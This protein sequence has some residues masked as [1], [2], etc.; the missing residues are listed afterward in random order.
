MPNALLALPLP[1]RRQL[2]CNERLTTDLTLVNPLEVRVSPSFT[3]DEFHRAVLA[4]VHENDVSIAAMESKVANALWNERNL[5]IPDV[6]KQAISLPCNTHAE[7][8]NLVSSDISLERLRIDSDGLVL[9]SR[10]P[11]NNPE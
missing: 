9:G 10:T 8:A 4:I 3:K 6:R 2:R 11:Y 5:L 7:I 1:E